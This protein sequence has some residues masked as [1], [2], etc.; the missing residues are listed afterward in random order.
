MTKNN[1]VININVYV[2][3]FS[4]QTLKYSRIEKYKSSHTNSMTIFIGLPYKN[5][6]ILGASLYI[7]MY[8]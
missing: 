1:N 7:T 4:H 6:L 8:I 2:Y 5:I 3:V